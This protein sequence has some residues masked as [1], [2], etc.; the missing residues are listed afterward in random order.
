MRDW[1][2]GDGLLTLRNNAAAAFLRTT[3]FFIVSFVAVF[4]EV[5]ARHAAATAALYVLDR[6]QAVVYPEVV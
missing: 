5:A 2:P 4:L 6:L 3:S 1:L